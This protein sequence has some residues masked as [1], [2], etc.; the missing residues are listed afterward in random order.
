MT[1][2]I[3]LQ[4][5]HSIFANAQNYSLLNYGWR[6]ETYADVN[7]SIYSRIPSYGV[8]NLSTG[9]R[10]P[11]GQ[12]K[13]DIS[14]WAKNALDKHYFLGLV[15]SGNGVYAGSAAQPRTI[16]ASLKYSF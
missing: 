13:I 12:N 16:G 3:S 7:N 15:N 14:L 4:H 10:I 2:N 8:L 9:I 6:S 11:H 5:K 1:A